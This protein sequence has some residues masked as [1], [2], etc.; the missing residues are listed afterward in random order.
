M[1]SVVM[2]SVAGAGR[3]VRTYLGATPTA[4]NWASGRA[5]ALLSHIF[6]INDTRVCRGGFVKHPSMCSQALRITERSHS[7]TPPH[8]AACYQPFVHGCAGSE[9]AVLAGRDA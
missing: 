9:G 1:H 7:C 8:A 2:R 3:A 6:C 5:W 4:Y